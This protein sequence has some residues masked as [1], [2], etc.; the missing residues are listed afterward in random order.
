MFEMF[1]CSSA[2]SSATLLAVTGGGK[3]ANGSKEA[4]LASL[5]PTLRDISATHQYFCAYELRSD[6]SSRKGEAFL[7]HGGAGVALMIVPVV[8]SILW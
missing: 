5:R 7:A 8:W 3:F 4:A 6:L 2:C 1:S